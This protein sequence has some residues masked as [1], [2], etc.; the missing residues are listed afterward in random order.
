MSIGSK[1]STLLATICEV[2]ESLDGVVVMAADAA[3]G[4]VLSFCK[5]SETILR[6][7]DRIVRTGVDGLAFREL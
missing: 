1:H 5:L 7:C 6:I 4:A 2:V 3:V